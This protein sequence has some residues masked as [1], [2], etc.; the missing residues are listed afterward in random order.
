MTCFWKVWSRCSTGFSW[1]R[2]LCETTPVFPKEP[3]KD[4]TVQSE[5]TSTRCGCG[6]IT[7]NSRWRPRC[8][9]RNPTWKWPW[10]RTEGLPKM[11]LAVPSSPRPHL[12]T[13][14]SGLCSLCLRAC[15][16]SF[17][18]PLFSSLA[19]VSLVSRPYHQP[20][21][22]L[23]LRRGTGDHPGHSTPISNSVFRCRCCKM[24]K[25][26][27]CESSLVAVLGTMFQII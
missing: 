24:T 22:C 25:C 27:L 2:T 16:V 9:S 6:R 3:K 12:T 19:R 26:V 5:S 23:T 17:Y 20:Q 15:H 18:C 8:G 14:F 1:S 4:L 11:T 13:N 21:S 10:L 7:S